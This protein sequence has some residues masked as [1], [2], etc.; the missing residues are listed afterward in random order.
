ML[1]NVTFETV[2][3]QRLS[4]RYLLHLPAGHGESGQRWPLVM[5]LHGL[6]ECGDDLNL[7]KKHGIPKLLEQGQEFPFVAISP[8]CPAGSWWT[9]ELEGLKALIEDA[10]ARYNI[11]P[12]RVYLTGLSMGGYGTWHLALLYP[13]LFAAIAPIC[14]GGIPPLASRIATLPVW[15][16]HGALDDVVPLQASEAMVDALKAAGSNVRFTVYPDLNHNSWDVTYDNP[17]LYEWLLGQRRE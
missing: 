12:A 15:A 9:L 14:G 11:D 4:V 8:Q 13:K 17:A 5:F 16:F 2:S 6:G 1:H 7:I 3:T 10:I